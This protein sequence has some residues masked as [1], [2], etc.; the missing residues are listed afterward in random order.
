MDNKTGMA[1]KWTG[2]IIMIVGII[3]SIILGDQLRVDWSYNLSVCIAGILS[4]T[5]FGLVLI[6][7]GEIIGILDDNRKYLKKLT[8]ASR[9]SQSDP[10][11]TLMEELP[12]L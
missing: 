10:H 1:L 4:S 2:W 9:E 12:D 11:E 5:V 6:G 3:G 7:F 8:K